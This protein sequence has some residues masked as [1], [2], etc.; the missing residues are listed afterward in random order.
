MNIRLLTV[1]EVSGCLG[2]S[3]RTVRRLIEQKD[4]PIHRIGRSI[5]ISSKDL[6]RYIAAARHA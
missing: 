5:R 2:I 3:V 4:L 1:E 6:E